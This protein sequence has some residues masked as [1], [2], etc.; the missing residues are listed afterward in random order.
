MSR[1]LFVITFLFLTFPLFAQNDQPANGLDI[2]YVLK[3]KRAHSGTVQIMQDE[4][5]KTQV[6]EHIQWNRK[7]NKMNGFR[8]RVFSDSGQSARSKAGSERARFESAYP[9]IKTYVDF[10]SPNWKLYVGDFRTK[11]EALSFLQKIKSSF[12]KAF[13]VNQ[14]INYPE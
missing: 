5:L 2:F 10:D 6:N 3:E 1:F 11:S 9:N 12:P 13:I 4:R 7:S 14:K 8:I